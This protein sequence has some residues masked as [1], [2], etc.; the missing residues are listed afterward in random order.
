MDR[1]RHLD[2]SHQ[3]NRSRHLNS[4]SHGLRKIPKVQES[5]EI[6]LADGTVMMGHLFIEATSRIQDVLNSPTPFFP[7]IDEDGQLHLINKA[8]VARVRPFDS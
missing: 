8:V 2:R 6:T 3:V 1:S 7:F 5:A 4:S